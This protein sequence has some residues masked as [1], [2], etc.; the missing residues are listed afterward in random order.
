MKRIHLSA[1]H[2]GKQVNEISIDWQIV[3][4]KDPAAAMQ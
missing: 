3:V 4:T 1:L 2:I